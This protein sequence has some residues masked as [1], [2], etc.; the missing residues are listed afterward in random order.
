MRKKRKKHEI[1]STYKKCLPNKNHICANVSFA[2]TKAIVNNSTSRT[3]LAGR[4]TPK[5]SLNHTLSLHI[6]LLYTLRIDV[7]EIH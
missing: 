6:L 1:T 5:E 7:F 3:S 2:Q 4:H